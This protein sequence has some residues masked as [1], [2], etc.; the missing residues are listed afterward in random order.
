M[1]AARNFTAE[2]EFEVWAAVSTRVMEAARKPFPV[3]LV[4]ELVTGPRTNEVRYPGGPQM[5][6]SRRATRAYWTSA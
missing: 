6:R 1:E 4:G 2:S 3:P 5:R